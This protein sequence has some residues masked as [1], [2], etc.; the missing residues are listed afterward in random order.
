MTWSAV[1]LGVPRSPDGYLNQL[2]ILRQFD[3]AWSE[4]KRDRF[5]NVGSGFF[6]GFTGGCTPREFRTNS[7]VAGHLRVKLQND[8]ERH[9]FSICCELHSNGAHW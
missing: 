6:L 9:N 8:S 3:F 1:S 7:R 5:P 4:I 2:G